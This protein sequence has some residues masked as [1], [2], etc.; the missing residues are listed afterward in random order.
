MKTNSIISLTLVA[1]ATVQAVSLRGNSNEHTNDTTNERNLQNAYVRPLQWF[2]GDRSRND[3]LSC[4][5][6]QANVANGAGLI[7]TANHNNDV[8]LQ[9]RRSNLSRQ[10][11]VIYN[12]QPFE[13]G[14]TNGPAYNVYNQDN[15]P[16]HY[17]NVH[18][19]SKDVNMALKDDGSGRQLWRFDHDQYNSDIS[20]DH[21]FEIRVAGGVRHQYRSLGPVST[22]LANTGGS[23]VQLTTQDSIGSS[24]FGPVTWELI[25]CLAV[26]SPDNL[27]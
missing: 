4:V 11:W 21:Q 14:F 18:E 7:L 8:S 6:R 5:I 3:A 24:N 15:S 13:F 10:R 27:F 12:Q 22:L 19:Y 1:Q 2:E 17:L 23:H 9:P 20:Y 16:N 25:D 26:E